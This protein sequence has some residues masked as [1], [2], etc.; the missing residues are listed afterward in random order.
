[1]NRDRK[2]VACSEIDKEMEKLGIGR[3]EYK[4]KW[5]V[6][7]GQF[8]RELA[9]ERK[10]KSGQSASDVYVST[11]RF[12]KLLKFLVIVN[13]GTKGFDTMKRPSTEDV[14]NEENKTPKKIKEE[15]ER[16]RLLVL[17][18]AVGILTNQTL[19]AALSE[20]EAFGMVVAKTLSRLS[21]RAKVLTKKRINDILFQAEFCPEQATGQTGPSY[22]SIYGTAA[23]AKQYFPS[24]DPFTSYHQAL[25]S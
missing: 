4:Y 7:R 3:E 13:N 14:E 2:D 12:Y 21:D 24:S 25:N 16:K 20:E 18:K 9:M 8:M 1:M 5:K 17:D 11:W 6:L 19:A 22:R 10:K 15:L 23:G